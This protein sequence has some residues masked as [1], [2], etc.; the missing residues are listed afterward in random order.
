MSVSFIA[1]ADDNVTTA[2]LQ[3]IHKLYNDGGRPRSC[4]TFMNSTMMVDCNV[5][6]QN[7]LRLQALQR[8]RVEEKNFFFLFT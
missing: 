4:K 7:D 1:M 6:L 2:T 3:S 8:W 5:A